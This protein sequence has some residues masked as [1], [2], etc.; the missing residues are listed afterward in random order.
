M[1]ESLYNYSNELMELAL[2]EEPIPEALIHKVLRE[3]TLHLQIQPVL[4]GSALH[5]IG[6]QPVLDAVAA[7][8]PS[9]PDVPPVEG[10]D[11]DQKHK[12]KGKAAEAATAERRQK[13]PPQAR[14]RRAVLRPGVQDPAVQDGRP[15]LGAHLLGHAR[16]QPPRA[17]FDARQEGKRRPAL[18]H[19]RQQERRAARIGPGGRHRRRHRPARLDHRR[20]ALRHPRADPAGVDRVSRDGHLD[21]D[22]A[23]E[24]RRPQEA[25]RNARRCSASRTRRSAPT[26][27]RKPAR[28]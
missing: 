11:V 25:G 9:P 7:Y 14:S 5:G 22:R 20:H 28:R 21:G 6:V 8:L 16:A 19:S 23:G 27:I 12:G 17:E 26:R 18:A 10:I 1:L 24:H 2:A 3:A 4:C 13:D 15:V